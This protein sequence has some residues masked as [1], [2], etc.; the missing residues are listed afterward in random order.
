MH[1]LHPYCS[2]TSD[3]DLKDVVFTL[4]TKKSEKIKELLKDTNLNFV[5]AGTVPS[6]LYHASAVISGNFVQF[7]ILSATELLQ[8]EGFSKKDAE[9][10][11]NQLILSSVKNTV[12]GINGISGPASRGDITTIKTEAVALAEKNK[13]VAEI[14]KKINNLIKKAVNN[15]TIF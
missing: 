15:G 2:I 12:L 7:F 1:L 9:L 11:I 13:E 10:L 8:N 4:W 3:T 5:F 14:F 6:P